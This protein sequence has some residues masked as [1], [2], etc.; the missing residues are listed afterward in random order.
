MLFGSGSRGYTVRPINNDDEYRYYNS[1][2]TTERL[3]DITTF[4][5]KSLRETLIE[6]N[7]TVMEALLRYTMS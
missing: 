5:P 2:V 6:N 4:G 3:D 7:L 1:P